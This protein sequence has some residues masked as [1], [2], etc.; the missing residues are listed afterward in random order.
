MVDIPSKIIALQC[1]WIRRP[2]DN[3]FHE[4]KLIPRYLI[5]KSFDTSFKFHSNL[6]FKSNKIKF[7]PSFYK[8]IIRN[9]RKSVLLLSLKYILAFCHNI[10]DTIKVFN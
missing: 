6:H 3:S 4:W 5:E 7:F 9:S 1:S 10:C 8:Q 2:Y